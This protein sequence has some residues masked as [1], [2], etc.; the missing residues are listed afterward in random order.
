[1]LKVGLTGGIASGKS[2]VDQILKELGCHVFDADQIARDV[3]L[4]DKE[5]YEKVVAEFGSEILQEDGLIDRAKLGSIVFGDESKRRKLN[6][7]LHPIII[8]EQ[9]RALRSVE[10]ADPKGIAVID[11]SLMLETG[12]YKRFD[13]IVVVYC[14]GEVQIQ[15]LMHRNKYSR[16]EAE[17]RV[18]SQMPSEEKFKYA[19]YL[20]DTSGTFEQTREQVVK[21]FE[22]LRSL[23]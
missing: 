13:K 14:D 12:S 17:A 16:E 9:D 1:M 22:Q 10:E 20:I 8:A 19:D 5:G 6:T 11:A 15:R 3:V 18:A 7:I 4:P 2:H 21:L 23:A